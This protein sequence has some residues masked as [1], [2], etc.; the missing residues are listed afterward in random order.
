MSSFLVHRHFA[1]A[2]APGD[3]SVPSWSN[4]V[5][6]A[7]SAETWRPED[8]TTDISGRASNFWDRLWGAVTNT[9]EE[10]TENLTDEQAQEVEDSAGYPS[11][12]V[13]GVLAMAGLLYF[14]R[15]GF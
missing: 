3:Y 4:P 9:G 2:A 1:G 15:R 6:I 14:L 8:I 10:N 5:N 12:G 7:P 11:S 13:F